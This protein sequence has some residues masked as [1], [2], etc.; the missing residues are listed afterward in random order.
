[1][2]VNTRKTV[3]ELGSVVLQFDF[4]DASSVAAIPATLY[5][6]LTDDAGTIINSRHHVA[7]AAPAAT[8]YLAL[9]GN[10]CAVLSDT[11]NKERVLL[12]EWTYVESLT[13]TTIPQ[14]EEVL[15]SIRDTVH[16]A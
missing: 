14:T 1:M 11:D 10:D 4:T 9:S 5:W 16:G 7:V 13:G 2:P 3:N 12:L 6:T 15:F 8:T